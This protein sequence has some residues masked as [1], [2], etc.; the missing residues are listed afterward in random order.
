MLAQL[1][2][3]HVHDDES[4][5]ALAAAVRSVLALLPLPDAVLVSGDLAEH[6]AAAE[7]EPVRE[8]SPRCRCPCTPSPATTTTPKH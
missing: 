4:A 7:Y 5:A 3:P 6:A 8:C 2:D 1:S